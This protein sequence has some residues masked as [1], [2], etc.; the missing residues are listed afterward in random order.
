MSHHFASFVHLC[1][2]FSYWFGQ[3]Q[4]GCKCCGNHDFFSVCLLL[5][6]GFWGVFFC[7]VFFLFVCLFFVVFFETGFH[8]IALAGFELSEISL[9][10]AGIKGVHHHT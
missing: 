7:V 3:V 5:N 8:Y 10:S 4:H 9:L 6:S 2:A 1:V